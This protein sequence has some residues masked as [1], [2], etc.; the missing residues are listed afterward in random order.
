MLAQGIGAALHGLLSKAELN[1]RISRGERG[2]SGQPAL[3][4]KGLGL[5]GAWMP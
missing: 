4:G 2:C 5:Q 3:Q 1:N